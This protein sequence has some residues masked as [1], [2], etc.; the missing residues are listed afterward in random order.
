MDNTV[1][2]II[3]GVAGLLIGFVIAKLLEKGKATKTLSNAKREA[4]GIIKEAKKE[5]EIIKKEHQAMKWVKPIDMLEYP[6]P[7]ADIP[8]I[9][10]LR[11]ML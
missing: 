2:L 8:L 4:S 6:M 5:G 7:E 3:A 9:S 11:E 1:I 10:N